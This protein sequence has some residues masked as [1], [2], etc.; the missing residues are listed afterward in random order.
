MRSAAVASAS[1]SRTRGWRIRALT[2]AVLACPAT[3]RRCPAS[4]RTT[5]AP[6]VRNGGSGGY[7]RAASSRS[8]WHLDELDLRRWAKEGE[9]SNDLFGFL[10]TESNVKAGGV[11]PKAMPVILRTT[12]EIGPG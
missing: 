12:E 8:R 9:T 11:H 10:T 2:R 7:G 6:I 1:R 3:F 5:F 4:I